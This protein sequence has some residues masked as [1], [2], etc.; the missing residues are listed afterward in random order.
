MCLFPFINFSALG[1][2]LPCRLRPALAGL[3]RAKGKPLSAFT[4]S[5]GKFWAALQENF[6]LDGIF[7]RGLHGWHGLPLTKGNE[8]SEDR[9]CSRGRQPLL[10]L[11]PSVQSE[12]DRSVCEAFQTTEPPR[13]K[14]D[15]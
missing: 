7:Y 13:V 9:V 1:G 4:F 3:R 5:F 15:G 2:F 6:E 11:L 10:S 8:G 14:R 12:R